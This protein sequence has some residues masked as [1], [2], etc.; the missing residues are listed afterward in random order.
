MG[1]CEEVSRG[2]ATQMGLN[3]LKSGWVLSESGGKKKAMFVAK[4]VAYSLFRVWMFAKHRVISFVL[5]QP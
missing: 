3:I 5:N 1:T 2:D 4:E